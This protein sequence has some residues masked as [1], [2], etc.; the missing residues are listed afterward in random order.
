[1]YTKKPHSQVIYFENKTKRF[2]HDIVKVEEGTMIHLIA[3]NGVEFVINKDKVN[4]VICIP[5]ELGDYNVEQ[6]LDEVKE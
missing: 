5:N 3:K 6:L 1:M 4:F 2:V